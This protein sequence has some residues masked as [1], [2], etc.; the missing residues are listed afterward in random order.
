MLPRVFFPKHEDNKMK[1]EG[2]V[3]CVWIAYGVI[4]FEKTPK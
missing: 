4:F 2:D 3:A 1:H